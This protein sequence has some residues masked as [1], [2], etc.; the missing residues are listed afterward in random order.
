[1]QL[2]YPELIEGLNRTKEGY[3]IPTKGGLESF[4]RTGEAISEKTRRFGLFT[5]GLSKRSIG[6]KKAMSFRQRRNLNINKRCF[7]LFTLSLSKGSISQKNN[8]FIS[9]KGG[10]ESFARTGE[11]ISEKTRDVSACL[12]WACRRAQQNKNGVCHADGRKHL[13]ENKRRFSLFTLSLSKGSIGQ[14]TSFVIPTKGGLE[15]F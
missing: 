7:G 6:Q 13:S 5:L 4:A 3:V 15:S 2:V 9:T 1:F 8:W 14:K 12:P 11:A 10:L